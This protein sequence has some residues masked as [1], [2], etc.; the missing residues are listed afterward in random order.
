VSVGWKVYV[1]QSL[2][3][4]LCPGPVP[5]VELS[6]GRHFRARCLVEDERVCVAEHGRTAEP[7]HERDDFRWLATALQRITEA[8]DLVDPVTL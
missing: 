6:L 1:R 5:Y 8:D 3:A 2:S 4:E 7:S